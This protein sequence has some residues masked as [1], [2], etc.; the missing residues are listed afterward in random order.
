MISK[1]LNDAIAAF[2]LLTQSEQDRL[3]AFMQ[4]PP[5]VM[6]ELP[7]IELAKPEA[8]RRPSQKFTR[9]SEEDTLVLMQFDEDSQRMTDNERKREYRRLVRLLGRSPSAVKNKLWKIRHGEQ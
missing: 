4:A 6:S 7:R 5:S 3:I 9:W 8:A 2:A 1:Q